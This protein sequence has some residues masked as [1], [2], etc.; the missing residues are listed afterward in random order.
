MKLSNGRA[1]VSRNT[2]S[3]AVGLA[4]A[5][6][7]LSVSQL[8]MGADAPSDSLAEV[9]VTGTRIT[10]PAGMS[11]PTPVAELK[12][13]ELQAMSPSSI[14]AALTQLP[15]FAG[16]SATTENFGQLASGGFFNSP[17]GGSLN[18]RGLGTKRTLTLLDGRRMV[19]STAYGGPDINLF[20]EEVLKSVEIVTG[21]ASASYGTDA[22]SGVV[23]YILDTK[24][25]GFRGTAQAGFSGMGDGQS[26]KYTLA[27]GS[28]LGEKSH[29]LFSANYNTRDEI[30]GFAGRD[31]YD[32]CG[33]IQ[34]PV[35]ANV[36]LIAG[37]SPAT[38]NAATY[39]PANGGYSADVPRLIPRCDLHSTQLTYDG[40]ITVAGKKYELSSDGTARPFVSTLPTTGPAATS[41]LQSGGGGQNLSE[42]N[43]SLLPAWSLKKAFAYL[44]HDVTDNLNIFAQAMYA[45]QKIRYTA[46]VGDIG[47]VPPQNFTIFRDNA[48][49][50]ANIAAIMDA[51]GLTTPGSSITMT[52]AATPEDWGTGHFANNNDMTTFTAGFKGTITSNGFLNDW[53]YNGYAQYG[54][55]RLD[56]V[57]EQ[58]LRLDRVYLAVDAVKNP[59]TGAIQCRVT[60][61]SGNVPGCVPLNPFGSGNASAAAVDWIKGYDDNVAVTTKPFI[62]YD[63]SA[64][65]IYGDPYSYIGDEDKH[66][67]ATTEQSIVE[68]NADGKLFDAWA[69][70][71]SGAVGAHYRKESIDQKVWDSQGNTAA[72]PTYF[73]VWCPDNVAIL[74]PNQAGYQA[75]CAQ[76]IAQGIRPPGVIG[77]K[78]VPS[79]PYTNSVDTQFSNVPFIA[80]SFNV[81]E[82][83]AETLFPLISEKPWM[84]NLT[85]DASA[86]WANYEGSGSIW[87]YKA[88]LNAAFTD[89]VRLRGTYSHDARAAN[90]AERFD[91]TGGFT[92]GINDPLA[93]PGWVQGTLVTTVTGG[94]PE[95]DPEQADTYTAGIVYRPDWAQGLD[96]SVDWL[97]VNIKGAI[98]QL[99]AQNVINQCYLEGDQDQCKLI[100]RDPTTNF[101][102]YVPQ[103]YQNLSHAKNESIDAEIG[104]THGVHILGGNEQMSFRLLGTY[105]LESSTTNTAG[106]KTDLTGGVLEQLQTT[107]INAT[108]TYNNGPFSWFMQARYL[109]GGDL[110][111]RYNQERLLGTTAAGVTTVT[112]SAVIYDVADNKVGSSLYWDTRLGYT[113]PTGDGTLEIFANV[114]N[115]FDKDPPLI[116]GEAIVSQTGGGYDVIGRFFTLGIN[117]RF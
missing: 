103:L 86:R 50:P 107:R 60:Q 73:P 27:F 13:D 40:L 94:N 2:C 24:M 57:Q 83:Y 65:P 43:T 104:Y 117:L 112:G 78:G 18:L 33:L 19:P 74:L 79:N 6:S 63:T 10:L 9:T 77:V 105:L 97:S 23:N 15:Q 82:L 26:Q 116:L 54:Q 21:G 114:N 87:S 96:M 48:F 8:A 37:S 101:I 55:N 25:D 59:T 36:G 49:L 4:I 102:L 52:K 32:G 45:E 113:I 71:V 31:W 115:L 98:E 64:Q 51:A 99:T 111:A 81:T 93:P 28:D 42:A 69:G 44:D 66:R 106:V 12:A 30:Y 20:P 35:P 108:M 17:G 70:A 47:P 75:R 80:G 90:I 1:S 38:Y 29:I 110:S 72:D 5:A 62:G 7:Q 91:R 58:G 41:G 95:V 85:L 39:L 100:V 14:T 22:V 34:N 3:V 92:A 89:E 16:Q 11:T 67:R 53:H 61:V 68:L 56:A 88:G 109:G 46:R 76:Q 84:K